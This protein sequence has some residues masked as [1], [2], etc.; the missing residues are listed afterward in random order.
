METVNVKASRN[1]PIL[2]A[3]GL[4]GNIGNLIAA[5]VSSRRAAVVTDDNVDREYGEAMMKS[6]ENA[7]FSAVKFVFPHGESSKSHTTLLRLY[8]FLAENSFTRSDML[9][10]LGGGVVGDLT[11]FAAATYMRGIDFVQVP[12][13]LLA[14]VDSSVGG[15]TAVDISGGKNLVGAFYQPCLVAADTNTLMTLTDEF[16]ADGMAEV[17]KYGMIKSAELF[18]ILSDPQLDMNPDNIVDIVKRCVTIKAQ[19]VENDERDTGER[20]L[21]NFGHTLGHAIEKYYNFSGIT[22]GAAVAI[23]MSI[24]THLAEEKGMCKSGVA[25]KLDALLKHFRL[26][27]TTEAPMDI[28]FKYSLGDKKRN[29]KGIDIVICSDIGTSSSIRM[30]IDEYADFLGVNKENI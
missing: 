9:I 17:I 19:V 15:K 27:T 25:D 16:F 5:S 26:P 11:G 1:Y 7:G 6:M 8:D 12:T 22:H 2:I 21:L 13:S 29:S 14:Q 23:G 24:F 3:N 4:F 18:N 30:S 20:V 28:L 10:A